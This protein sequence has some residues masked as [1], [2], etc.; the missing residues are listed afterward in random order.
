MPGEGKVHSNSL[1]DYIVR[2]VG[3]LKRMKGVEVGEVEP[4]EVVPSPL[5]AAV[6]VLGSGTFEGVPDGMAMTIMPLTPVDWAELFRAYATDFKVRICDIFAYVNGSFN[7]PKVVSDKIAPWIG[8]VFFPVKWA[9]AEQWF[10]CHRRESLASSSAVDEDRSM[11]LVLVIPA[12]AMVRV[13]GRAEYEANEHLSAEELPEWQAEDMRADLIYWA[14]YCRVPHARKAD[15][16]ERALRVAWFPGIVERSKTE[17]RLCSVCNDLRLVLAG[18][19]LGM[20]GQ[21]RFE[22]VRWT[23]RSCLRRWLL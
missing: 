10:L 7:G 11:Q 18:I 2:F 15:T 1:C 5:S 12:G 9:G 17:Y 3:Q 21:G 14:H 22:E 16:V 23:M 6:M 13:S 19:G 20:A 4:E 8:K